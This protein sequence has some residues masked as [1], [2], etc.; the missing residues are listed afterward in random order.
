MKPIYPIK[1]SHDIIK[2]MSWVNSPEYSKY[3]LHIS[4]VCKTFPS[5]LIAYSADTDAEKFTSL[6]SED[7]IK[8]GI[9]VFK[10]EYPVPLS[11]LSYALTSRNIPLGIYIEND[12]SEV[13]MTFISTHGGLFDEQDLLTS[14]CPKSN[15]TGVI[16]HTDLLSS[17]V[18]NL[19]GFV[20]IFIEKGFSFSELICPF[21]ELEQRL[22]DCSEFSLLFEKDIK[23]YKAIISSNGSKLRLFKSDS[24]E[25]PTEEIA[26]ILC[27]YLKYERL[28]TGTILCP[29]ESK[30]MFSEFGNFQGIN[31]TSSDICYNAAFT[32]LFLGWWKDGLITLQGSSCMGDGILAAIYF[33]EALRN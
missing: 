30:K 21:V 13:T 29:I 17:Y 14:Y 7:I 2:D 10:P 32:D 3:I 24:S 19:K 28:C 11:A 31:G 6:I 1:I 18:N 15:K 33:V 4:N 16:G 9:N 22:R 5:L 20:D 12:S 25:I 26:Q 8:H 23:G 27:K